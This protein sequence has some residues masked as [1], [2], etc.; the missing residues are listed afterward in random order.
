MGV[1]RESF[2]CC[3]FFASWRLCASAFLRTR[4]QRKDAEAQRTQS[5]A[6]RCSGSA[7]EWAGRH[8]VGEAR[9]TGDIMTDPSELPNQTVQGT[10]GEPRRFGFYAEAHARGLGWWLY[11]VPDLFRW[12]AADSLG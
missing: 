3:S 8:R 4:F 10:F 1:D 12:A 9:P 7:V 5:F 2:S 6:E 11:S